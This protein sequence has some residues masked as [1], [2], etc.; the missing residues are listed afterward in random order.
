MSGLSAYQHDGEE[1][2]YDG[3]MTQ[4]EILTALEE[5]EKKR[6]QLWKLEAEALSRLD[7]GELKDKKEKEG[8][9]DYLLQNELFYFDIHEVPN[10][11]TIILIGRRRTGKS[12]LTRWI[13]YNKR[14]VFPFGLVMTQTKYNK[15]WSTY[16]N[17]NSVWGDYSALALGRLIQRQAFLAKNNVYGVDPRVFVVLDDLAADS[18]LRYDYMLRAFFYY[19]RHLK[20]F[21]V[22]T[23]QWFKSLAPGC[24]E[25][26]DYIFLFG[27]TNINELEAIY[28]EYGAGVPKDLFIQLVRRYATESSCFVVNPHGRTPLERFFQ[29]RAQDPGPFRM[30][31]EEMWKV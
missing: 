21:V 7:S 12:F 16:I 4:E 13:L 27:M 24:R 9:Y 1:D 30:G 3:P 15:F 23:S 5:N 18:Q 10:D 25:N 29:Y 14:K 20:A 17:E 28:E 11:S 19:G 8:V 22:V 6:D 26:A 31:C 2:N